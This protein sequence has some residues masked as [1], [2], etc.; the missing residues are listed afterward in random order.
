VSVRRQCRASKSVIAPVCVCVCV[1]A[2]VRQ[3]KS[4]SL[5]REKERD[6]DTRVGRQPV[7]ERW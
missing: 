6:S 5:N 2:R 3:A 1:R 4:H 7:N